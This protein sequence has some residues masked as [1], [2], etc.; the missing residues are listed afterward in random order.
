MTAPILKNLQ[1]LTKEREVLDEKRL[2]E[3]SELSY[4]V[5]KDIEAGR[6]SLHTPYAFGDAVAHLLRTKEGKSEILEDYTSIFHRARAFCHYTD[7]AAF[8]LFLSEHLTDAC[9]SPFPKVAEKRTSLKI[10]YV[11]SA[12]AE[13]AY[14]RIAEHMSDV[15][16]LYVGNANEACAAVAAS[17]ADCALLPVSYGNEE[18]LAAMENLAVRYKT[19]VTASVKASL[20][21]GKEALWALFSLS[22]SPIFQ[23]ERRCL[24]LQITTNSYADVC[25]LMSFFSVFGFSVSSYSSFPLEYGSIS[26]RVV[27]NGKGDDRALWFFLALLARDFTLLGSYFEL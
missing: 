10:A 19:Y 24:S 15:T 1:V 16:V 25:D 20:G 3:I 11:P 18:R 22:S 21:E 7:I 23:T 2:Y 27:L 13:E 12:F 14:Q 4:S 26:T 9:F 5:F 17:E 8:S 6:V